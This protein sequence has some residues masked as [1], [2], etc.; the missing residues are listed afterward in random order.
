MTDD[1]P[2]DELLVDLTDGV[3]TL[4]INRADA[5]NSLTYTLR[6]SLVEQFQRADGDLAVRCVVL[7]SA[8]EK[9]FCTGA[10]LRSRPPM[11]P[12]PEGAPE[13]AMGDVSRMIATGWQRVIASILDCSKPVIGGVN[14]TAAG[15][16]FH[17]AI[18]CDLVIA[19]ENAR[20]I[21]VF[22]R[23][24]IAPDAGGAYLLPRLVGIQK[25]KEIC[26]F[27]DDISAADAERI[28]FVNK[29]VPAA[30]LDKTVTEW[31]QR[32][33][34]GPTPAISTAKRLINLSLD[35]SRQQ[36]FADEAWGQELVG[37]SQDQRE[38]MLAFMERRD[39]QY[40][41]Y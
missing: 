28:G 15:G 4:R 40:K 23:R 10:D 29:V 9:H 30:D 5:S 1:A 14:G 31:A 35:S 32:L 24:G 38:G 34:S 21:S 26:F 41:G 3:L 11:L 6:E 33:A 13:R 17:L 22:V 19:A 36:A 7:T 18:A 20:F 39:P 2:N 25:A 27:G 37:T 12:K 16:G 8:G